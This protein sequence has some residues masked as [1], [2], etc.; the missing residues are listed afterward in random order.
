MQKIVSLFQR[1]YDTDR[2]VRDEVVPGAEWVLAGEGVATRKMD[3]VCTMVRGGK[4]Y[5]RHELTAE[6][7]AAGKIP[8]NW[9]PADEPDYNTDKQLGW[10]PVGDGPE[11]K[12]LRDFRPMGATANEWRATQSALKA[13]APSTMNRETTPIAFPATR[14]GIRSAERTPS[15][16]NSSSPSTEM[17]RSGASDS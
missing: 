8:P 10:V 2:L 11:D 7:R 17:T 5:K 3:G 6:K 14:I 13:R 12:Y 1:N 16:V 15:S 9:E 4:L